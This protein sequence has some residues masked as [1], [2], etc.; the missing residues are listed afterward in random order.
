[1][2]LRITELDPER[3]LDDWLRVRNQGGGH[4][5]TAERWRQSE[6]MAS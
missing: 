4:P 2:T 5:L 1:M 3:E 6:R